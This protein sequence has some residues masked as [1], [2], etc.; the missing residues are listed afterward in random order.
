MTKAATQFNPISPAY[1]YLSLQA[2]SGKQRFCPA[3]RGF[4]DDG[5]AG[6]ATLLVFFCCCVGVVSPDNMALLY[7]PPV[8]HSMDR[9][10]NKE[11][12]RTYF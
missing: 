9:E 6:K 5:L 8:D 7:F 3:W 1:L 10:G 12:Y 11:T 2:A 4:L